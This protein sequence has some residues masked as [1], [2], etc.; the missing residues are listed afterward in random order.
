MAAAEAANPV[1]MAVMPNS[2]AAGRKPV[3][4]RHSSI[5]TWPDTGRHS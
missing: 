2:V 1:M 5:H 3:C 4:R